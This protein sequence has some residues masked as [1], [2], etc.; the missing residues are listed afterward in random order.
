MPNRSGRRPCCICGRWF[1]VDPRVGARQ[2]TC[3]LPACRKERNKRACKRWREDH[4][5]QVRADRLRRRLPAD[6]APTR[7]QILAQP[8]CKFSPVVLRHV[9]GPELMVVLEELARVLLLAMR[10]EMRAE[11]GQRPSS[12]QK[13]LPAPQRH[14]TAGARAP[15]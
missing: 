8:L 3:E 9:M 2:R 6:P 11:I 13:V 7:E 15:P 1:T 14:E 12:S 4:P 10:H 5:D